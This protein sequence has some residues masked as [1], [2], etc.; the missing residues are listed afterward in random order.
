[1]S[2]GGSIGE[3][4]ALQNDN[5]AHTAPTLPAVMMVSLVWLIC[6]II[7]NLVDYAPLPTGLVIAFSAIL[8]VTT[9]LLTRHFFKRLTERNREKFAAQYRAT[10]EAETRR[11]LE[12][13]RKAGII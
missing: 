1:M 11:K 12:E 5:P 13:A 9:G 10:Q 2:F 8:G 7:F 3:G 6:L 4:L